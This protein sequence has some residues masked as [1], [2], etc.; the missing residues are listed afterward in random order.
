MHSWNVRGLDMSNRKYLVKK[1]CDNLKD[2]DIVCLQEIKIVG[3]QAYTILKFIWDQSIG[4]YSNH[5]R[6]KG[7]NAILVGL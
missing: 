1:Q 5:L 7:D 3:F 2:K 6:G 4:F